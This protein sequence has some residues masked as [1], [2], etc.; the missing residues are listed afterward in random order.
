LR[1]EGIGQ[2]VQRGELWRL[3]YDDCSHQQWVFSGNSRRLL[4]VADVEA[5]VRQHYMMCSECAWDAL[6]RQH[7]Q[8]L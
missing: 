8:C 2:V 7:S 3:I 4:D 1:V 6:R 5:E